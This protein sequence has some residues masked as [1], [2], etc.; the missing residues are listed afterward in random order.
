MA[1][2]HAE[3]SP[4]T[5]CRRTKTKCSLI[6]PV[7][8]PRERKRAEYP[9]SNEAALPPKNTASSSWT[10]KHAVAGSSD[11]LPG[12]APP[13]D[14]SSYQPLLGL[15]LALNRDVINHIDSSFTSLETE[16]ST[17]G[18]RIPPLMARMDQ[19]EREVTSL[20]DIFSNPPSEG[21]SHSS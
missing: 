10:N 15:L 6:P 11:I 17:L 2:P 21:S 12:N 5:N 7:S 9:H 14:L 20:V 16:L 1:D 13:P 3:K 18:Q 4:C 8:Q 19:A